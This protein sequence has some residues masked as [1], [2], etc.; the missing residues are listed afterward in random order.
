MPE[1]QPNPTPDPEPKPVHSVIK[2]DPPVKV[3]PV[4]EP[5]VK[6]PTM[7]QDEIDALL[8]KANN[9]D[10]IAS[11]Q[12]LST[13]IADHFRAK[14]GTVRKSEPTPVEPSDEQ[15]PRITELIQ[16]NARNEIALFALSHPDME[17]YKNDMSSMINRYGM[18][19]EDA[20]RFSKS[21]K[22]QTV[23]KPTEVA[24]AAPTVETNSSAGIGQDGDSGL[25]DLERRINDPKATPRLDD[26]IDLAI[27]A[28]KLKHADK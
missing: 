21:A 3:E 25:A 26:A 15:D 13:K 24:P 14:T 5:V 27:E 28:A 20:Y 19:L 10:L 8:E 16:R 11:D 22:Q 4:V 9:Y 18:S 12:E 23:Q 2:E 1:V 6:K 17:E 7:T